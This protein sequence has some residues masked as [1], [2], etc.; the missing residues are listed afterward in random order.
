MYGFIAQE[1]KTA[2]DTH[3]ITDFSGWVEHEGNGNQQGISYEMFVMPLVKAVQELSAK[4][5][6]LE[7]RLS[8]LENG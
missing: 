5:D 8:A 7:A 3:G 2:L 4:N 1:V 6:A